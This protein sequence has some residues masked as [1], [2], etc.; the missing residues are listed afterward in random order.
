MRANNIGEL[1]K[2]GYKPVPVKEELRKNLIENKTDPFPGIVGYEKSVIPSIKNAILA[3]HDFILLGLRGQAKTRILRSLVNLL[4]EYIPVVDKCEI[5]DNPFNPI[6]KRC[7][8]LIS[9]M[10]DKTPVSWLHRDLRYNE[11]L[12][13][14]DV[15]ISDLIGDIDPIKAANERLALSDEEVVH[16]GLIPRTNRGIFSINELPDLNSR[17]QVGLLNILEERDLQI[18]GFALRLDLDILLVFTANPEDYTN[19]GTII[20][21][22]KDRIDSQIM[23]HYPR[24]IEDALRITEQESWIKRDSGFELTIPYVIKE[25]NEQIAFEARKSEFVDQTSGV[26]ARVPISCMETVVSNMERRS[27]KNGEK[28]IMARVL[29]SYA[30][31]PSISGKIELVYEGEQ[32]GPVAVANRIIGQAINKVFQKYFPNPYRKQSKKKTQIKEE[33]QEDS[34]YREIINWFSKGNSV[35]LSDEMSEEEYKKELGQVPDLFNVAKNHFKTDKK[36]EI[37]LA[38]ELVLE[39]LY[40][41]SVI[42]KESFDTGITYKDMLKTMFE[43]IEA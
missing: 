2:S 37:H 15:T 3:R 21:P 11:K 6:C 40:Q 35:Q 4:D 10:G 18:R 42:A 26:S 31:V 17:I 13:T 41:N 34:V 5:N 24:N 39:G 12:A 9:Q 36:E 8:K 33:E 1:K 14:P 29:D 7:K 28:K 43:S 16:Y 38:M 20:T 19:R 32:Q 27:I 23:T 30:V 22:L 25:I